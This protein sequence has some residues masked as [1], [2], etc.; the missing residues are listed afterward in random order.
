[1]KRVVLALLA[2]ISVTGCERFEGPVQVKQMGLVVAEGEYDNGARTG[3][4]TYYD[5]GGEIKG[6]GTYKNGSMVSG[7]EIQY[8]D[9]Q[10]KKSEGTWT[11]GQRDGYW[12]EYFRSGAKKAEGMYLYGKKTG[13]WKVYDPSGYY[14][15]EK[16]FENDKQVGWREFKKGRLGHPLGG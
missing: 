12:I 3:T 1:M 10:Q 2:I 5:V 16:V 11:N 15:T 7:L 13:V 4:W 9:N 8:H 14:T 6:Q